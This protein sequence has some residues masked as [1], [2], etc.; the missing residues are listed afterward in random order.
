M[1]KNLGNYVISALFVIHNYGIR[2]KPRL[3]LISPKDPPPPPIS[4][5][6][7]PLFLFSFPFLPSLLFFYF[8]YFY[9]FGG[10]TAWEARPFRPSDLL[11][12]PFLFFFLF[13]FFLFFPLP[14]PLLFLSSL[15]FF[16]FFFFFFAGG[17]GGGGGGGKARSA[18]P[19]LD[20]RLVRVE[21]VLHCVDFSF[22]F[23][24]KAKATGKEINLYWVYLKAFYPG[25]ISGG[26]IK[27]FGDSSSFLSPYLIS[28][29]IAYATAQAF[30][31]GGG[32]EVGKQG[33]TLLLWQTDV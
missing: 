22:S 24:A 11:L 25:L 8:F 2:N 6:V 1:R 3:N 27:F 16:F 23:Q 19:P 18:P 29:I 21:N 15:F 20:P 28:G 7:S 10:L 33:F 14:F 12:P 26:I 17:G 5:P 31:D 9:F 4:T 32:N 30:D 13:F